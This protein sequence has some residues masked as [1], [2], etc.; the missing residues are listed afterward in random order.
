MFRFSDGT[1]ASLERF[2][3]YGDSQTPIQTESEQ[4]HSLLMISKILLL[5]LVLLNK[6]YPTDIMTI[7]NLKKTTKPNLT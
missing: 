2:P 4:F 7:V 1:R 6:T 5:I 3:S